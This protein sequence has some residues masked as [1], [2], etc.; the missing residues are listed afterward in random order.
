M[1][2]AGD[3]V[4]VITK[5]KNYRGILMPKPEILKS[6]SVVIK[7]DSGY[8][9][10]IDERKIKKIKVIKKAKPKK[11]KKKKIKKNKKLPTVSI[12]STGGT[13][14]SKVDYTTGGTYASLTA[15]DFVEL[16]PK[17]TKFANIRAKRILQIMSEDVNPNDWIKIAKEV[18]KELD[19]KDVAGVVITH[20]TDTLHYTAAMLS[21][22][23]PKL[24][25]PIILVGA[26]RSTDRGSS[27]TFMNLIC[28]VISATQKIGEVLVCMHATP[29]DDFCYLH[30]ATKVRKMH[31][32]RRD[33]FRSIN[34][35]PI[36]KVFPN[37]V[38]EYLIDYKEPDEKTEI[39]LKIDK[40]V[41][42]VYVYPGMDPKVL[43]N[44]KKYHGIVLMGTGLGHVPTN[45]KLSLIPKIKS[46]V[47]KRI[48]VC[49]TSQCLYGRT[50]E[51]VYS[52]LRKL[53]NTGA[54]FCEDMLPEVAYVKLMHVLGKT[55]KL[56][57][58]KELMQKNLHGE[59][60]N[61]ISITM[62]MN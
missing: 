44:Y 14:S 25:K 61:S 9:I 41:A 31:T 19:R 26:Q 42:L 18:K 29:N 13:I 27:D 32:S 28:S 56:D 16:E 33:A 52:N 58:V 35:F 3:L 62:F 6:K 15:E 57:K 37:G 60:N 2:K 10:G 50:H 54:I 46:L 4:E 1:A 30:R 22:M 38:V 17:L 55:R 48:A 5:D 36:A 53:E 43:D 21:F 20:G 59:I 7:L 23:F 40:K 34:Q 47:K 39:N 49:I 8:N 11:E 51:F 45:G 12:L 24:S